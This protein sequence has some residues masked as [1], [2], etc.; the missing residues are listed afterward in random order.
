MKC[1][2]FVI[3]T[4]TSSDPSVVNMAQS[5]YNNYSTLLSSSLQVK[6]PLDPQIKIEN[7]NK[8]SL[9]P[10]TYSPSNSCVP[11]VISQN[12]ITAS[13]YGKTYLI[14]KQKTNAEF[15]KAIRLSTKNVNVNTIEYKLNGLIMVGFTDT[16]TEVPLI[17]QVLTFATSHS[18]QSP[19]SPPRRSRITW[20]FKIPGPGL[21]G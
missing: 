21:D 2:W 11:V 3:T 20:N 13:C 10:D 12:I 15:I 18:T 17:V 1:R 6:Q 16:F 8:R 5:A 4:P 14:K 9:G 7:S 19:G